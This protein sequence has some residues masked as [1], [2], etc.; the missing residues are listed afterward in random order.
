MRDGPHRD[1]L[2]ALERQLIQL[3]YRWKIYCQLYDSGEGNL[4]LLNKSGSNVFALFQ[5][6]LI[7]DLMMGLCRLADPAISMGKE[8]ASLENLVSKLDA[9]LSDDSKIYIRSTLAELTSHLEKV[10]VLRNK[11]MSHSDLAHAL[12]ITLLPR[13]TYGELEGALEAAVALLK[14]I[15]GRVYAYSSTYEPHIP[16]GRDGEKLLRVLAKA[17]GEIQLGG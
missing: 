6:L 11:A 17:H 1:L 13:P 3:C 14:E 10:R 7:D 15:T 9:H 2:N 4:A 8:N 12:D 16:A 5:K